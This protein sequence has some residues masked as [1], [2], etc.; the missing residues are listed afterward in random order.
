MIAKNHCLCESDLLRVLQVI[1]F[2]GK[3]P[4]W[5]YFCMY[6]YIYMQ[7]QHSGNTILWKFSIIYENGILGVKVFPLLWD[8][9]HWCQT[10]YYK[11]VENE[12]NEKCKGHMMGT[13]SSK[14]GKLTIGKELH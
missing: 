8:C 2:Y 5:S 11:Y 7:D 13:S 10:H 14:K 12:L 3:Y 6:N 1:F 4:F 9:G